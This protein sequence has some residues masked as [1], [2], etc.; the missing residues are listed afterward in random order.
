MKQTIDERN[1]MNFFYLLDSINQSIKQILND[2]KY[3]NYIYTIKCITLYLFYL[4]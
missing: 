1:E 4:L 3:T 2:H